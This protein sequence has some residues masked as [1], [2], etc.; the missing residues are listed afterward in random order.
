M[1]HLDLTT[2]TLGDA[3]FDAAIDDRYFEDY[4][5]GAVYEYGHLTVTEADILDFARQYDP[6]PIH[7]D[8]AFAETGPFEGLIASGWQSAGLAMRLL[9]DHYLSHVASLASPGVD[10]LRWPV[11]LQPGDVVRVRTS[12]VESRLSQSKPDR[13]IVRTDV[14]LLNQEDKCPV[15]FRA[16]NFIMRR[17]AVE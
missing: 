16:M 4:H 15:S 2:R 3:D 14:Q 12:I 5:P 7:T 8:P 13:G 1:D 11:P 17:P 6:Q 9:V 10:E